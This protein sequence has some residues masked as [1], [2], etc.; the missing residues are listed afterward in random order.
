MKTTDLLT[1]LDQA[2]LLSVKDIM[3]STEESMFLDTCLEHTVLRAIVTY[4]GEGFA[5]FRDAVYSSTPTT[6]DKITVHKSDV[7]P[8]PAIPIDESSITG[9]AEVHD[10]IFTDIGYDV[11]SAI[12]SKVVRIIFGDQLSVSRMRSV[13]TNRVGHDHPHR[14]FLNLAL[15][16]GLFHYQIHAAGGILETHWGN[17]SAGAR[18]PGSLS[19][20]NTL[21]DRKPIVITSA[22]PYRVSRD[23]IF[24][25]LYGRLIHC[26]EL[27]AKCSSLDE[28]A[29]TV[30]LDTLKIHCREV[31]KQ[32]A[33]PRVCASLRNDRKQHPDTPKGDMV[34]ENATL[35]LRDALL[36]REFT[37]AIKSGDSGRVR[38]MLKLLA[39]GYRGMGRTK[40]AYETLTLLHN[41]TH[42]WPTPLRY[43]IPPIYLLWIHL[44]LF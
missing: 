32:Y 27:V 12:F 1:S 26:L 2:A 41:L 34:F 36:L 38:I 5:H 42:V 44:T 39:L 16:P 9:N 14:S 28:Y 25:S 35:F 15:G 24:V 10:R 19:F 4:G 31:I 8:M 3:L 17:P 22:P 23:L 7:W 21:L 6:D 13:E 33:N 30:D 37:D 40:Y 29:R 43:E 11:T 20:H 18:D